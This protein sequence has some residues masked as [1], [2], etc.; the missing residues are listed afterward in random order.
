MLSR[1]EEYLPHRKDEHGRYLSEQSIIVQHEWTATPKVEEWIDLLWEWLRAKFENLERKSSTFEAKVTVDVDQLF[2][3][4][5][6]GLV[7]SMLAVGKDLAGGGLGQRI[8]VASGRQKDPNDIYDRIIDAVGKSRASS[9]FFFQVGESSRFDVNNPPHLYEVQQ[10]INEVAL[11]SPVGLHPSY[12]SSDQPSKMT[13]EIERLRQIISSSVYDSRQHYLR[14]RLPDTFR[15]LA[16]VGIKDDYSIGYTDR[17][18]FRAGTCKAFQI[19]DLERDEILP[20]REHPMA[21][22][23]LVASRIHLRT[24]EAWKELDA[25]IS[26]VKSHGGQLITTWH[27]EVLAKSDEGYSTWDIFERFISDA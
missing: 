5:A 22:M 11:G 6:K 26:T 18:G 9:M 20:I 25:F 17:N 21:W 10:R 23:D 27:P 1:Y 8:A 14:F 3:L 13:S 19:Y 16:E 24:D 2:A 7:R 4:K 12:F 15:L